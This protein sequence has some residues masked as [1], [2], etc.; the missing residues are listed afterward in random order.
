[1]QA[2]EKWRI[3]NPPTYI[4]RNWKTIIPPESNKKAAARTKR[5]PNGVTAPSA[6]PQASMAATPA[7]VAVA[8]AAAPAAAS[9]PD[10]SGGA[11]GANGAHRG[12]QKREGAPAANGTGSGADHA[13]L[14]QEPA[15]L[16]SAIASL[17]PVDMTQPPPQVLPF[18]V[19]IK[20]VLSSH[21]MDKVACQYSHIVMG[22]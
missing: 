21:L 16:N 22:I 5:A 19:L 18:Q 3:P 12:K 6:A 10:R 2:G 8:A 14:K 20:F 1:M 13:H 17:P 7:A 11:A 9:A 4:K 15:T